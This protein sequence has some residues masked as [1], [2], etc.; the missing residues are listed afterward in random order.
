MRY[1]SC[2]YRACCRSLKRSKTEIIAVQRVFYKQEFSFACMCPRSP[3]LTWNADNTVTQDQW[4]L[5]MSTQVSYSLKLNWFGMFIFLS[6]DRI[7]SRRTRSK[8]GE[9][10]ASSLRCLSIW[11]SCSLLHR[12]PWVRIILKFTRWST[13]EPNSW[14]F[15]VWPNVLVLC[16]LYNTLHS[17]NYAG[18]G[19]RE[20]LSRERFFTYAF[21]TS[22]VWCE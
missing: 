22:A 8:A 18:I 17:Q 11:L 19:R 14:H 16:A 4:M 13:T 9:L 15:I 12:H 10:C 21:V 2:S 20:G 6:V 1:V 7:L 3:Y 5:V